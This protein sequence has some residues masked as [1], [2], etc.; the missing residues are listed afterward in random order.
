MK[1]NERRAKRHHVHGGEEGTVLIS[2]KLT[3]SQPVI[4]HARK[5]QIRGI[6]GQE[7]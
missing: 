5:K 2:F 1:T 7:H 4:L 6:T 3:L